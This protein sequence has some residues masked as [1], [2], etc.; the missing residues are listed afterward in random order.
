MV[1]RAGVASKTH[2]K[3]FQKHCEINR[4][5]ISHSPEWLW[6]GE[7]QGLRSEPLPTVAGVSSTILMESVLF[8]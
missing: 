8:S 5:F 2:H 1:A 6:V 3:S 7:K 4:V